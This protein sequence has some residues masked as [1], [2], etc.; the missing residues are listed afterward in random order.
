MNAFEL[1]R[2]ICFTTS[3]GTPR[4]RYSKVAP[5]LILCPEVNS[6]FPFFAANCILRKKILRVIGTFLL[7]VLKAKRWSLGPGSLSD[8]WLKKNSCG[9]VALF[10]LAQNTT[11]PVTVVF[12]RGIEKAVTLLKKRSC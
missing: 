2:P 8:K 7:C 9:S 1:Q 4:S 11:S 12:V 5:I 3:K 10:C 6:T